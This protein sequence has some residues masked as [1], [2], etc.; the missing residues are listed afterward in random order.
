MTAKAKEMPP[1]ALKQLPNPARDC[2][3]LEVL[4][5]GE[6]PMLSAG[7]WSEFEEWFDSWN[8]EEALR[9]AAIV[10]PGPVLLYGPTGTGK[11]ML[12]KS[13]AASMKGRVAVV[14]EVHRIVD[15]LLG[16]TGQRIDK[17]FRTCNRDHALLVIEELDGLTTSRDSQRGSCSTENNRITV[18]LM[19]MIELAQ[20]PIVATTNRLDAM[21]PALMRRFEFKIK[22]DPL[23]E[24]GRKVLLTEILGRTPPTE[25]LALSLHEAMPMI[26]RIKRREFLKGLKR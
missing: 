12:A 10:M 20:F 19:R 23:S 14:L 15:S 6:P 9:R 8:R 25:L 7:I 26:Q 4:L 13:I 11:S 21:D 5:P 18:A 22:L 24:E 3:D 2:E 17:V 1:Q 16:G